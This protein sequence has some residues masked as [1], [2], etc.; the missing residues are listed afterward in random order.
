[1]QTGTSRRRGAAHGPYLGY[2]E[3]ETQVRDASAVV[4]H[5]GPGTIMLC[6]VARQACQSSMPRSAD[7]GEHVDDHQR[8]VLA[9]GRR[10]RRDLLAETEDDFRAHIEVVLKR[11]GGAPATRSDARSR[12]M[13][14]ARFEGSCE[15]LFSTRGATASGAAPGREA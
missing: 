2:A 5:G 13:T 3:M 6:R 9:P 12:A 10:R 8:R 4:C 14:A 1:M 7:R 11:W 15:G